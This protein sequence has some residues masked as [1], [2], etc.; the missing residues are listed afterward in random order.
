MYTKMLLP[1]P[2]LRMKEQNPVL[3]DADHAGGGTALLAADLLGQEM[4]GA[5]QRH[6]DHKL[7][8]TNQT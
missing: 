8:K 6:G 5:K 3:A 2:R 7:W 1:Y 4:V